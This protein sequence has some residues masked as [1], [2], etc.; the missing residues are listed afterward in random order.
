MLMN[1]VLVQPLLSL[2]EG[3]HLALLK[4]IETSTND[5]VQ[6][7]AALSLVFS[8]SEVEQRYGDAP[9]HGK[10]KNARK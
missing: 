8:R 3:A 7:D 6:G 4:A 9:F 2:Q 1:K 5:A 10:M